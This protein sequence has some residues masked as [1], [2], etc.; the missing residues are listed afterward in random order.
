MKMER[1][2]FLSLKFLWLTAASLSF[3]FRVA[4]FNEIIQHLM[5][6]TVDTRSHKPCLQS[7]HNH[8]SQQQPAEDFSFVFFWANKGFH[9]VEEKCCVANSTT[10]M[11]EIDKTATTT[12]KHNCREVSFHDRILI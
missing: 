1:K 4:S 2:S 9:V 7:V 11:I 8:D 3:S 10:V 6:P 12:E 5:S